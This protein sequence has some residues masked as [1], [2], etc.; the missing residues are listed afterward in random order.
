LVTGVQTCALPISIVLLLGVAGIAAAAG[1]V[2]TLRVA[3]L[4]PTTYDSAYQHLEH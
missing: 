4:A 1:L 2:L 3:R